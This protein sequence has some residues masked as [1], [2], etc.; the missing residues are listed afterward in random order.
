MPADHES[1]ARWPA[2]NRFDDAPAATRDF[3]GDSTAGKLL[4]QARQL[5]E[6]GVRFVTVHTH[7]AL[8]G[9]L[10][11]DAHAEPQTAPATLYDYGNSLGPEW[12]RAIAALLVD[13]LQRGLLSET[14]V[15]CV[16]EMGRT[17][18]INERGGRDHWTLCWSGLLAGGGLAGG[19]VIGT[20]DSRAA[21]PVESPI[22][23]SQVAATI[24]DRLRVDVGPGTLAERSALERADAAPLPTAIA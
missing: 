2:L 3:Y 10:T 9:R 24:L 19:Q 1:P 7:D 8:R 18:R 6:A 12:D 23:L 13:L 22:A 15:V 17:P 5:V 16:G 14:L 4:F 11:W 21:E 20:S